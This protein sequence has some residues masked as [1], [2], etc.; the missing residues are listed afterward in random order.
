MKEII[1]TPEDSKSPFPEYP[2][3]PWLPN[4]HRDRQSPA[5]HT[6]RAGENGGTISHPISVTSDSPTGRESQ[7][8]SLKRDVS[9]NYRM[10]QQNLRS[11]MTQRANKPSQTAIPSTEP[12]EPLPA[13]SA[14]DEREDE[15]SSPSTV[16]Q[17]VDAL[18]T[19]VDECVANSGDHRKV[20]SHIFGR[21]KLCTSQ[22][23]PECWIFYCRKHYQRH[24]FRAKSTGWKRTQFDIIKRQ[25]TRLESWGGVIDWE[26][27]LRKKER[28]ELAVENRKAILNKTEP[29]Y[30]ES[31]LEPYLGRGKSYRD[32]D[33]LL[34]VVENEI[35]LT[36]ADD[37]PGFELLP[38][39]D[40]KIHPPL[41]A[42]RATPKKASH[43]S[44]AKAGAKRKRAATTTSQL[45]A[46]DAK[47]ATKRRRLAS[48]PEM[49]ATPE[50]SDGD[51]PAT[52]TNASSTELPAADAKPQTK[53]RRLLQASQ[54]LDTPEP[55]E[56]ARVS[57]SPVLSSSVEGFQPVNK[58]QRALPIRSTRR[59]SN[60]NE[61]DDT[62]GSHSRDEIDDA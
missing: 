13:E 39:I 48:A 35:N 6:Q 45:P 33:D 60:S 12:P 40:R 17:V 18:C 30:R 44:K 38:N 52:T 41:K 34:D 42:T 58:P 55:S 54:M 2:E 10:F 36:N 23:P 21:N 1:P 32:I 9:P 28:D 5:L 11:Q 62:E 46:T 4:A 15:Q 27:A 3:Y 22:I 31:F 25:L 26:I 49:P 53:R 14:D 29:D 57:K 61:Q 37:L 50:L 8:H 56:D 16:P 47:P 51:T 7:Q 19:A 59:N 20:V 24:R 43:S